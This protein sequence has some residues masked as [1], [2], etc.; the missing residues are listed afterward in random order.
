MSNT[1]EHVLNAQELADA[2]D[3]VEQLRLLVHE[4]QIHNAGYRERAAGGCLAIAQQHHHAIVFL[5]E[6]QLFASAFSLFRPLFEAYVRGEWLSLSAG[7]P[8]V[9]AFL[10]GREPPRIDCL[11]DELEM[12]DSFK[13]KTLSKFKL[14]AWRIMCDYT[15]TGGLHVQRWNTDAGIEPDYSRGE[16]LELLRFADVIASLT[17][18]ALARLIGND[19]LAFRA[20]DLLKTR[21]AAHKLA[22]GIEDPF[23][24]PAEG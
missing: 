21:T 16:V 12:T 24:R 23:E 1:Y 14:S 18:S 11:L 7:E 6:H 9:A 8:A 4:T 17:V 13:E 3:Y 5:I 22:G 2:G 19:E 10:K 15:H 20:L